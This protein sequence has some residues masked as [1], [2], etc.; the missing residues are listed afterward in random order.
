MKRL[1]LLATG[2]LSVHLSA[3]EVLID[4]V[5]IYDGQ[6]D[7]YQADM[8][9]R[10]GVIAE[11][12][13]NLT[14]TGSIIDGRAKTLSAGIFN[15]NTHL[16]VV[17]VGAIKDTVDYRSDN[18]DYTASLS[19]A[20]AINPYSVLIP[21]NRSLGL[22]RALV[23]PENDNHIF[24]GSAALIQLRDDQM[25]L[26]PSV[27]MVVNLGQHGKDV[28][29]GS[30]ATGLAMLRTALDEAK[31]FA[32]YE[33]QIMKGE[34]R[35]LSLSYH[36]LAALQPVLSGDLPLIVKVD[37]AA[38]ILRVVELA[39]QYKLSLV[40]M[41]A[42]EAWRV[43]SE[44]ANAKVAVIMDPINNLPMGYDSLGARLDAAAILNQAGVELVFTGMG[45]D[46][47]H[48]AALVRQSA[49][50][51]V[52]HGLPVNA[53]IKAITSTPARLFNAEKFGGIQIG[54][55]ADL[56]IWDGH[57]LEAMSIPEHVYV[58][59]KAMSL[60]SRASRL[61]DRYLQRIRAF[62]GN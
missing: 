23:V 52:A 28:A 33:S 53:A 9:L 21:Y 14:T 38:D 57:P 39:Q 32:A 6:K 48:N 27:G 37:R 59:G 35:D 2:L 49:A 31:E 18:I 41:G 10:D 54:Q 12:G 46:A 1:V 43:A 15:G 50:N 29:G 13:Q 56:V 16:G 19:V 25:I 17:E 5:M 61:A 3:A 47:S 7:P 60:V 26:N 45:D 24:A 58:G 42:R 11:I 34:Y 36:D 51:A 44:L 30:R 40:L 8:L 4:N 22:T 55:P 62:Q 20:E